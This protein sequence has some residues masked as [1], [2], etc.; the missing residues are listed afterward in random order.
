MTEQGELFTKRDAGGTMIAEQEITDDLILRRCRSVR[1]ALRM[2]VDCSPYEEKEI[3]AR[4]AELTGYEYQLSH[5]SEALNGGKK[6][7]DP[8]HIPV[9][10]KICGNW[11]PTRYL[12]I[13]KGNEMKP[14]KA[15][16]EI[17][18][19]RLR[20]EL[21]REREKNR[22]IAEFMKEIGHG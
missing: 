9:L 18:N 22:V 14:K 3:I 4:L 21:D 8:N 6:N 7:L 11:I 5:F 17:E 12:V 16:L 10:E 13:T 15:A 2:C 20:E 1:N 19:E